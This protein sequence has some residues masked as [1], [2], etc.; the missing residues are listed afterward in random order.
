MAPFLKPLFWMLHFPGHTLNRG[1]SFCIGLLFAAGAASP[2]AAA[3]VISEFMASNSKTLSDG[4]G[5]SS[6]W[7]EIH[8]PDT[9]ALDLVGWHL[10][11]S[12]ADLPLLQYFIEEPDARYLERNGLD[13]EG[14]YYKMQSPLTSA[15]VYPEYFPGFNPD[16]G[17]GAKKRTRENEDHRDLQEIVSGTASGNSTRKEFL[18]DNFDVPQ[19]INYMAASVLF[20]DWDRYPKNHF[21]YRDTEGTGLWQMHPWDADL[22][23]GY[24]GWMTDQINAAHPTM[25][26]P[27]YGEGSYPGVYDLMH[28]EVDADKAKWG[29]PF[30]TRQNLRQSI[31]ALLNNYLTGWRIE[32]GIRFEFAPGTVIPSNSSAYL[33]PS[34]SGFQSRSVSPRGRQGLLVLGE[35]RGQLSSRGETVTLIRNNGTVADTLTDPGDPSPAQNDL[36]ISEIHFAPA[37]P[38]A[39]DF[40]FLELVNV[41][42]APL[43]LTGARFTDGITYNFPEGTELLPGGRLILASNP[44][45]F[46][47][48]HPTV[49]VTVLGPWD[50]KLDNAGETIE[51]VDSSN[52]TVLRF[53]YNDRWYRAAER[54]G[55]SLVIRDLPGTPYDQWGERASWALSE[56]PEGTP[57]LADASFAIDYDA[58][59]Y[60]QFTELAVSPEVSDDLRRWS[61]AAQGQLSEFPNGDGSANLVLTIPATFEKGS[62]ESRYPFTRTNSPP[63][64]QP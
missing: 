6:D 34:V 42:A 3:P 36:R 33:T 23:G 14:A 55:H 10:T 30:G 26:H 9:D 46:A 32:D 52:E 53:T 35:Y 20:Q 43:D 39:S 7:I 40:E 56:R 50:G 13:P 18:S 63:L 37:G 24:A 45:A 61:A 47:L 41:G 17:A 19:I 16:G 64:S 12:A 11:D 51:L 25:S 4:D 2:L 49:E 27:L 58:W 31:D 38:N 62:T 5:E 8:N 48:R 60:H 15:A 44:A 54:L 29:M 28:T 59:S 57:G 21:M 1:R 22:S